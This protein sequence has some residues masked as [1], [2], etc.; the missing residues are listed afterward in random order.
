MYVISAPSGTGKTTVVRQL[1]SRHGDLIESISYTTRP[2]RAN[3]RDG[4]D[5]HFV[6]GDAFRELIDEGF[7]AEW[8]EV[9]GALYGTP[10]RPI[11]DAVAAGRIV[12][13]DVDVQGGMALKQH[14]PDAVT[15]FL[16]PPSEDELVRRLRGRGTEGEEQI[17]R[18]LRNAKHEMTFRDRY[19]HA[20][21]N[22]S[23]EGAVDRLA[24]LMGL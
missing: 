2:A 14:F 11:E 20:I 1:L 8:A 15:V 6:D 3:E 13:L 24:S 10:A 12:V 17:A 21:I 5:Y 22:D 7:F 18:R 9:H 4:V 23:V 16:L 19:D